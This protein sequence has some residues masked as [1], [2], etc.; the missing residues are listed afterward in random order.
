MVPSPWKIAGSAE[1]L[2][3]VDLGAGTAKL[4]WILHELQYLKYSLNDLDDLMREIEAL[5]DGHNS[6]IIE[7]QPKRP[8]LR[9]Q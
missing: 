9:N 2:E 3:E 4:I 5:K 8:L 6:L 1:E 7:A